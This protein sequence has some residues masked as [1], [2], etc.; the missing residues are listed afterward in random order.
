[1]RG[2]YQVAPAVDIIH[3]RQIPD[4]KA[5]LFPSN[6]NTIEVFR[7]KAVVAEPAP[8]LTRLFSGNPDLLR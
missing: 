6:S 2:K 7:L 4:Y 3:Y 8:L 5:V 1:M